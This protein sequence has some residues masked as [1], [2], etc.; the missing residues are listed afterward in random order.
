[1]NNHP[2][3]VNE[4]HFTTEGFPEVIAFCERDETSHIKTA[5]EETYDYILQERAVYTLKKFSHQWELIETLDKKV[6]RIS[7][8]QSLGMVLLQGLR[9]SDTDKGKQEERVNILIP[10]AKTDIE[11]SLAFMY[12]FGGYPSNY[13]ELTPELAIIL[14]RFIDPN[15]TF[16]AYSY[17]PAV[18][19]EW[20][21][22]ELKNAGLLQEGTNKTLWVYK[23]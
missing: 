23:K 5:T 10:I 21:R 2:K 3:R 16:L 6:I 12:Y 20:L 22:Q 1:M 15:L 8:G 9:F 17:V 11:K 14:D 7:T 19:L 18:Y 13:L 4:T